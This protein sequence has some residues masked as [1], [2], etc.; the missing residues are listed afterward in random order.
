MPILTSSSAAKQQE[1]TLMLG[2]QEMIF[3]TGLIGT[4]A[5]A[6]VLCQMGGTVAMGN[7]TVSAKPR[8]GV[9]FLPLQGVYQEKY[10]AGGRI[11]GSRFRKR[12]GRPGDQFVVLGRVVDRG[13]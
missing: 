1:F 6:T 8:V 10:Y 13:L 9:D 2:S 11:G 7:C 5:N 12:E 3:R 4:Q